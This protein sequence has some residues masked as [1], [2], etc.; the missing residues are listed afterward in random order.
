MKK[1]LLASTIAVLGTASVPAMAEQGKVYINPAVGYMTFDS[2]RSLDDTGL[3]ALGLEYQF[4]K[5]WGVEI[6]GLSGN[7]EH[8]VV[9]DTD[10]EAYRLDGLY[11]FNPVGKFKPYLAAGIGQADIDFGL[12]DYEED[13]YNMGGGVRYLINDSLS[14]RADVRAVHGDDNSTWDSL[15]TLGLSYAF[16]GTSSKPAPAPAPE[17]MAEPEPEPA[18]APA[19]VVPAAP[20][21]SDNDGVIDNDDQCPNTPAGVKVDVVGCP[22][23]ADKDGVADYLDQ[24]PD[25]AADAR[26][27]SKGCKLKKVRVEEI[28]MNVQFA[29]NSSIVPQSAMSE[30][31][32]VADFMK[33]HGDLV[34]DIEGHTD[35]MGKA[36]YNKYLSQRRA[37][38]VAKVLVDKFGI[39]TGRVIAV[40]Y[41]EEKPVATNDTAEGRQANRRVVAVLQKEV[42]E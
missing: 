37:D 36:S 41:G 3:G 20:A 22:L 33:A 17:P 1:A 8:D 2:D 25:S 16:G 19:P 15:V 18:P 35:S 10:L 4:H 42:E 5:H 38:S 13:Q 39:E 11:Y 31:Q 34:V 29:S 32:K 30:I 28:K 14:A 26:V 27:D 40:G 9:G 12:T 7:P 24:C 23:D 6:L 21:D